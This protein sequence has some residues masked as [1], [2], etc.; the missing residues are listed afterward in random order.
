MKDHVLAGGGLGALI[1][2]GSPGIVGTVVTSK[3]WLLLLG[4]AA[5]AGA[6][7]LMVKIVDAYQD[8]QIMAALNSLEPA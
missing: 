8:E 6:A 5:G 2:A 3:F 7:Y 4:F 1:G